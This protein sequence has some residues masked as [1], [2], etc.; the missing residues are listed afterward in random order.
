MNISMVAPATDPAVTAIVIR[1][2]MVSPASRLMAAYM[3]RPQP[4]RPPLGGPDKATKS[5]SNDVPAS[6]AANETFVALLIYPTQLLTCEAI[7][8]AAVA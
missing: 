8:A 1:A 3:A 5:I 6:V 7:A 4:Y 2:E